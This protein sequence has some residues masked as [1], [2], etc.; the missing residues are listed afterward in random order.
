LIRNESSQPIAISIDLDSGFMPWQQQALLFT[1]TGT[2]FIVGLP[3]RR[4]SAVRGCVDW[5]IHGWFTFVP[6]RR[7]WDQYVR[8]VEG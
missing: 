6:L 7:R 5:I 3:A 1:T 8:V 2:V 4:T